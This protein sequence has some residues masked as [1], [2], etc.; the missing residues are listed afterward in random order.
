M[1]KIENIQKRALRF[2]LNNYERDCKTL[3]KNF[4]KC[5]MEVRRLRTLALETFKALNDLKIFLLNEK[6]QRKGKTTWKYQTK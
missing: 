6:Y 4:N 1:N 2:L 5:T 3:L